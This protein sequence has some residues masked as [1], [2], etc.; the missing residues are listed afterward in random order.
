MTRSKVFLLS[1]FVLASV[2]LCQPAQDSLLV[3]S[4][5]GE[6]SAVGLWNLPKGKSVKPVAVWFHGGM[7]SSNCQKGLEA[8]G[9]FAALLPKFTVVSVSACGEKH[10]M[11]PVTSE[12]VDSALDSVATRRGKPIDSVK[13]I[14]ISDGALG[15][16]AYSVWGRR[17]V[18]ARTLISSYGASLG[19]ASS[20]ATQPK[21][22]TGRWMFIQGGKDRLYPAEATVPWIQSFCKAVQ[23]GSKTSGKEASCQLEFDSEG[24]HDWIYWQKKRKNWILKLFL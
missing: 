23:G 20:L 12:W 5:S 2:A 6:G 22:Q 9:A 10:W 18:D 15:V 11:N 7:T 19:E 21:L 17:I 4:K 13:V 16:I 24:E 3:R 14:G 1:L 8:G